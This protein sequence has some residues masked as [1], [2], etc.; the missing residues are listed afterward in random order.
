MAGNGV[1]PVAAVS[2]CVV[3]NGQ[4]LLAQRANP[5][6][7]GLWSLPGG[8]IEYGEPVRAAALRELKEETTIDAEIVRLL[9]CVDVIHRSAEGIITTHY[10][11]SVFG[12]RWLSGKATA[13]SDAKAIAWVN[14][15]DLEQY[16]MTPGTPELIRRVVPQLTEN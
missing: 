16:K 3:R 7:Y 13:S 1:K 10:V 15:G 12:A 14:P 9:D 4:V 11:L 8:H 2:V 6:A 5:R